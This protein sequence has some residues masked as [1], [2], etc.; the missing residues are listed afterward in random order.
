MRQ[1]IMTHVTVLVVLTVLL[2]YLA[3]SLVMYHK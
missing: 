3:A 1:K 2:T